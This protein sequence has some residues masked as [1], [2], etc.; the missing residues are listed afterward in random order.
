MDSGI[1]GKVD[2]AKRYSNETER[3]NITNLR[4]DF[5]GEHDT[6]E[7]SYVSGIWDCQCLFFVTRGVCSHT[8]AL[9]RVLDKV[10]GHKRE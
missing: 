9:Q 8:M 2:K 3:I 1:I 4:A 7:V 5:E 6:Y 10:I